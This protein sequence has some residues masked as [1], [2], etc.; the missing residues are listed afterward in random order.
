MLGVNDDAALDD[1]DAAASLPPTWASA[2]TWEGAPSESAAPG[3][4]ETARPSA[5]VVPEHRR[6]EPEK[7]AAVESAAAVG[8]QPRP[9]VVVAHAAGGEVRSRAQCIA[10][11][12]QVGTPRW[13]CCRC[14]LPELLLA[15]TPPAPR[16][17]STYLW[18][19]SSCSDSFLT[20]S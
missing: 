6:A 5:V 12:V 8:A 17:S 14:L 4:L 2:R 9:Q 15:Q 3:E 16:H 7:F 20:S 11:A 19:E 13:L 18:N 1:D 10:T